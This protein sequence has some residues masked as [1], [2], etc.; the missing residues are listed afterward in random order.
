MK[1]ITTLLLALTMVFALFSCGGGSEIDE[2]ADI[3]ESSEPTMITTYTTLTTSDVTL[4]SSQTTI[5]YG[6]DFEIRYENQNLAIPGPGMNE[7]DYKVTT[8]GQIF[9]HN[10]L[11]SV[12][13]GETWSTAMPDVST[14]QIKFDIS[15]ADIEDYEI[16]KSGK[17]LTANL[18][19]EQAEAL[20]GIA[21][22][23]DEDGVKL[24]VEHDGANLRGVNIS[25]TTE[26]GTVV[27]IVTSYTYDAV[28]S[29]FAPPVEEEPTEEEPSEE[30]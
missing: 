3:F 21:I 18:T 19:A 8:S 23:A 11:Y 5:V 4:E 14:E 13:G 6:E 24:V 28:V 12:D 15:A 16:A 2:F 1:K 25:Y 27:S 30:E 7:D 9:Y 26:N 22:A 10:G 17:Q 20:L 29:P